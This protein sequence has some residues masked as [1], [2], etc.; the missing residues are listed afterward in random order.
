[1]KYAEINKFLEIQKT[2]RMGGIPNECLRH[3]RRK[4][5]VHLMYLINHGIRLSYFSMSWKEANEITL[6]KPGRGPRF[7]KNL[8]PI[9]F[10]STTGK[11]FEE[12]ILKIVRRHVGERCMTNVSQFGIL[13]CHRTDFVT[14]NFD[15]N[16]STTTV[17]LDNEKA[18]ET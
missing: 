9:S 7:P 11:L 1:M 15:N 8:R 18:F 14:L 5:L 12:V 2:C 16:M 13:A 10:L 3:L 6:P 4:P 17:F